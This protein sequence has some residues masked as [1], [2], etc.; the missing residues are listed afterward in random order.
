MHINGKWLVRGGALLIIFGFFMPS[1]LVSCTLMPTAGQAIS[2]SQL[3]GPS[4]GIQ[5]QMILYLVLLGAL[6][7][8][9]FALLPTNRPSQQIQYL[10]AQ[11]LGLGLGAL[12]IVVTFISLYAQ[13]QQTGFSI[14][15]VFGFY[16]LILGYGL[17]TAGILMQFQENA[18]SGIRFSLQEAGLAPPQ[19]GPQLPRSQPTLGPRLEVIRGNLSVS[20]IPVHD[21]FLIGR[22]NSASLSLPDRSVSTQHARLRFAQ[23]IWFIQDQSA[24]GTFVNEKQIDATRLDPG[25]QIRIGDTVFIFRA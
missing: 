14:S 19:T 9:V 3:A 5:G 6:V 10:L 18:K 1:M 24:N 11:I 8:M 4:L 21:G 20:S 17:S 15:P 2:L 22:S 13:L 25:D 12:S 7:A 16:V 23:G